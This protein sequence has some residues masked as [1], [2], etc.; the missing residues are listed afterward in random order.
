MYIV[1]ILSALTSSTDSFCVLKIK[2]VKYDGFTIQYKHFSRF[3]NGKCRFW[4]GKCKVISDDV[5][6]GYRD[7][8]WTCKFLEQIFFSCQR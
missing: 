5:E 8:R 3:L 7:I 4:Y 6:L 2:E 1:H